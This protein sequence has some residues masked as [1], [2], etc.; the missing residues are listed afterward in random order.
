LLV[1]DSALVFV[2]AAFS[3]SINAGDVLEIALTTLIA[4][5][6]IEGMVSQ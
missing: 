1:L 6:A 2:V 4:N 3:V 5:G